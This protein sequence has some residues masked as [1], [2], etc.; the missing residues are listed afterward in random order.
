MTG[1]EGDLA[2]RQAWLDAIVDKQYELYARRDQKLQSI[3]TLDAFFMAVI[4]FAFDAQT[5]KPLAIVALGACLSLIFASILLALWHIR[6]TI[7]SGRSADVNPNV[8]ALTGIQSFA[9]WRAYCAAMRTL[10]PEVYFESAARQAYGMSLVN[11]RT[12][13]LVRF[14]VYATMSAALLLALAAIAQWS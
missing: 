6:P 12:Y 10:D 11:L 3:A 1:I 5:V 13:R 14:A 7:S 8:R 2:T 4:A 9:D